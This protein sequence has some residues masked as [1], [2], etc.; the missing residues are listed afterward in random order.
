M[1]QGS[2]NGDQVNPAK[3][4]V[5]GVNW[6]S[7]ED[8]LKE[9]FSQAGTVVYIRIIKDKQTGKSKGYAFV[10]MSTAEEAQKAIEL[11]NEQEVDGRKVSVN[12]A[13]PMEKRF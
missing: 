10:E 6:Q 13:R 12:V 1:D 2:F 8:S 5:G 3:L 11:F 7:T 9:A 4:F